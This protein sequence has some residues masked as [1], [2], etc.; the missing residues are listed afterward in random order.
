MQLLSAVFSSI[1][2][3]DGIIV[4]V[5]RHGFCTDGQDMGSTYI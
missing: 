5:S 4:L 1:D 3:K 2:L